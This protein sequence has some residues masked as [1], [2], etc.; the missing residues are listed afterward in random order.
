MVFIMPL[1]IHITRMAYNLFMLDLNMLLDTQ[2]TNN[3]TE[4]AYLITPDFGLTP[5]MRIHIYDHINTALGH[6]LNNEHPIILKKLV[7]TI[8][9]SLNA[10]V[11]ALFSIRDSNSFAPYEI[12]NYLYKQL[13][14]LLNLDG[15]SIL[16]DY[17]IIDHE[18][19]LEPEAE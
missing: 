4:Y 2:I 9:E 10:S 12:K 14:H 8:M 16:S 13:E 18:N 5:R 15:S 7:Q 3:P 19:I 6:M 1:P 11:L 17:I